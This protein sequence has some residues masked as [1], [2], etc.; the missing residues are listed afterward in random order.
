MTE[1]FPPNVRDKIR[2][3][4]FV[5][6]SLNELELRRWAS[7]TKFQLKLESKMALS[8]LSLN[9]DSLALATADQTAKG[10]FCDETLWDN[11]HAPYNKNLPPEIF[12]PRRKLWQNDQTLADFTI[13][14]TADRI[15]IVIEKMEAAANIGGADLDL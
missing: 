14:K 11:L 15:K 2:N 8:W 5:L 13:F 10:K 9:Q 4:R 12:K 7:E 6:V 3:Y 1:H